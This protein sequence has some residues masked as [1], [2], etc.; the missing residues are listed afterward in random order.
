MEFLTTSALCLPEY[1]GKKIISLKQK[2][3][4]KLEISGGD[5]YPAFAI[6]E[7]ENRR[8][9]R[10]KQTNEAT[11]TEEAVKQAFES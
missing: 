11:K 2:T 7:E 9:K 4:P 1:S 6:V 10:E 5:P 3:F 8:T